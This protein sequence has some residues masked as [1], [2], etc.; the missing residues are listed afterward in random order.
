VDLFRQSLLLH[1]DV[2]LHFGGD[3]DIWRDNERVGREVG[4]GPR[5][6]DRVEG[7]ASTRSTTRVSSPTL[8]AAR[9]DFPIFGLRASIDGLVGRLEGFSAKLR[10][11][12]GQLLQ[13]VP[14]FWVVHGHVGHG[15]DRIHPSILD[16]GRRKLQQHIA[17][18]RRT[19]DCFAP[20]DVQNR[21][22]AA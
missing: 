11:T 13:Q 15:T 3:S 9:A 10:L 5:V 1:R 7:V 8:L 20:R 4:D 12:Q 14:R 16:F 18:Y 2:R 17:R 6:I 21:A 22:R 19:S